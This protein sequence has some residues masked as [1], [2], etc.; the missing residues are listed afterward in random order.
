MKKVKI[1]VKELLIEHQITQSVLA[2][3][4][5]LRPNVISNLVRGYVDRISI[6]HIEKIA[7]ALDIEDMN[8]IISLIDSEQMELQFDSDDE[9]NIEKA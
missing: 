9:N 8:K 4:S 3:R 6:E 5:G 2:K 7:T 1:N